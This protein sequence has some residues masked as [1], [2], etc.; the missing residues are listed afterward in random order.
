MKWNRQK[1]NLNF[2]DKLK[3][4]EEIATSIQNP[5]IGIDETLK[6]YKEGIK[7][8]K[9]CKKMILEINTEER[10]WSKQE[11]KNKATQL[12]NLKSQPKLKNPSLSPSFNQKP[13]K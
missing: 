10:E 7:L 12:F 9:E 13:K 8:S 4:L 1:I 5:N 3:K 2:E 6:L 11:I